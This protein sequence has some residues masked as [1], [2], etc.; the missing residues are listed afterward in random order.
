VKLHR[1]VHLRA[2]EEVRA[3]VIRRNRKKKLLEKKRA[4]KLRAA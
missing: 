4:D 1:R 3:V 2:A